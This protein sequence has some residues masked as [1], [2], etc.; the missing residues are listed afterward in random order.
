VAEF[1]TGKRCPRLQGLSSYA[2]GYARSVDFKFAAQ[3]HPSRGGVW[4][5]GVELKGAL[6]L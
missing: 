5:L 3:G 4:C 1:A 2:T 6:R